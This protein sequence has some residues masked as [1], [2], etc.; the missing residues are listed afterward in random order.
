MIP[1]QFRTFAAFDE[2]GFSKQFHI[3]CRTR[4]Q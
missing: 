3:C 1:K 4:A 2:C